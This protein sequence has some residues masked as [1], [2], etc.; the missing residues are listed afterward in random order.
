MVVCGRLQFLVVP[1]AGFT[2]YYI[3]IPA[4]EQGPKKI[5]KSLVNC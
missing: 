1:V 5:L 4:V 3:L 2:D